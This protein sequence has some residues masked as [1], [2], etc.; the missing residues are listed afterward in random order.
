MSLEEQEQ[1]EEPHQNLSEGGVL[2][3]W[4]FRHSLNIQFKDQQQ[5][6]KSES[7]VWHW[8]PKSCLTFGFFWVFESL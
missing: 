8:R 7:G 4:N 2:E 6:F 1:Q 3:V 5:N